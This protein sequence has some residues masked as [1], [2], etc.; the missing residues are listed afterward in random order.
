MSDEQNYQEVHQN[1]D[2]ENKYKKLTDIEHVLIRPT[3]Y[4]GSV[5]AEK[6]VTEKYVTF[7][8]SDEKPKIVTAELT[9]S[10]GIITLFNE[11][12][13]NSY[14]EYIRT[15]KM[16][17]AERLTEL[18]VTIKRK[19]GILEV[20]DNGGIPVVLHK[21]ENMLLPT[22]LFGHLRSG[23]NYDDSRGDV[24]GTNGVGASLVNVMSKSFKVETCDGKNVY[25]GKWSNNMQTFEGDNVTKAKRDNSKG[26]TISAE[27]D[28]ARLG[29]EG[30]TQD[31]VDKFRT[32]TLE[33]AAMAASKDKPMK[34]IFTVLN[35][36]SNLA[37]SSEEFLFHSF[38]DYARLY[39]G[40]DENFNGFTLE[41][42]DFLVGPSTSDSLE[43][44][45]LLNSIR[46]DYGT[47]IDTLADRIVG[48]IRWFINKKHKIDLKPKQIKDRL[49]FI[50]KW[51]V[52]Q[53]S[54]N[55]Q[56]KDALVTPPKDFGY[57]VTEL[58]LKF[59]GW[60]DKSEIVARLLDFHKNKQQ[61]EENAA[62]R[63]ATKVKVNHQK[64]D[65]LLDASSRNQRNKCEIFLAEGDSAMNGVR[66]CRNA[67][68]QGAFGLGGKFSNV[69]YAKPADIIKVRGK[70]T[71][72]KAKNLMD[73]T[74]LQ[75]GVNALETLRWNRIN[76]MTDADYD[77]Y[78]IACQLVLFFR[79]F[80]P[81]LI[82]AGK[83]ARVLSPI[84]VARKD[85]DVKVYYTME[86]YQKDEAWL[87]KNKYQSKHI[88]GLA[89]LR[90]EE[91][92]DV[93]K[94][95]VLQKITED[96]EDWASL[97]QWFGDNADARKV[98]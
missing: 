1:A 86:D 52:P 74:G 81:E 96:S 26:T 19:S 21:G 71:A 57:D 84:M 50:S 64:I 58:P 48:H 95:P 11:L 12:V 78:A 75:F 16:R 97:E 73:A 49:R 4:I 46:C 42:M 85:K 34:V 2:I 55:N 14:D 15:L 24:S 32:R 43:S 31:L 90:P 7:P 35:E 38:Q 94:N 79:K 13:N 80:W 88:K 30:F 53:P 65:K 87:N 98:F 70:E 91:Y 89:A 93:I 72:S 36:E 3:I 40:V 56:T 76:I 5:I 18:R 63:R 83:I 17:P 67:E 62:V 9:Y 20:G 45:A 23:S 60:L 28:F 27:L 10:K 77:G 59:C 44:S 69:F 47:H 54:F 82:E 6:F 22:M 25:E 68:Y 29:M 8:D 41:K 51:S 61:E 37:D 39:E 66:R 33:V 92:A